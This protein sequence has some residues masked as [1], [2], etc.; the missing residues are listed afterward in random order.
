MKTVL[1]LIIG[2]VALAI[3]FVILYLAN[4]WKRLIW[5]NS[6]RVFRIR[7]DGSQYLSE[8]K[9]KWVVEK[10]FLCFFVNCSEILESDYFFSKDEAM[11]SLSQYLRELDKRQNPE[12]YIID[13]K[14][15]ISDP[16]RLIGTKKLE[17]KRIDYDKN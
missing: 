8:D 13:L 10:R 11:E 2:L 4:N 9:Y 5:E 16:K 6:S 12:Q 7:T 17:T 1:I 14:N 3:P 15:Q